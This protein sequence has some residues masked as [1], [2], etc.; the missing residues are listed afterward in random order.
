MHGTITTVLTLVLGLLTST[1][2]NASSAGDQAVFRDTYQQL[3]EINTTFSEGSCTRAAQAMAVRLSD[4]GMPEQDIH[5]IVPPEW[6]TQGKLVAILHGSK[7][8]LEPMLL[9]AH[10]DVV[11]ARREDWERDPFKLVE[12]NGYFYARGT[13]DNKAMA[14]IF[15]DALVRYKQIGYQPERTIKLALTC[16]EE[17]ASLF[18]G[19][20]YLVE[21][22]REL[23]D[24]G[25]ALNEG[26][27]GVLDKMGQRIY[28]GVQAGE[29]LYQDYSFEVTNP[30]GHSSRPVKDN[31]IYRLGHALERVSQYD[32]LVEFNDTTRAYFEQM[33]AIKSGQLGAD[34]QAI[35]QDPPEADALARIIT[36]P[37]Y[38]SILRT[39]CVATTI[40]GGDALNALP[41][42]VVANVNCRIFPGHSQQE[43]LETLERVVDDPGVAISFVNAPGT[44]SPPPPL[45][46]EILGPIEA[47]TGQM[48]PGVPVLPTMAAGYTDGRILTPA[49]IPT[50]GVS[51]LFVQPGTV[52]AHGVNEKL[53]VQSLYEGR[54]F[55]D[56]LIRLYAGGS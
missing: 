52:N 38:N 10:I 47:V 21:N 13:A 19:A 4:A 1:I 54:E 31:A 25:F 24:A 53:P 7:A 23:I 11:E 44:T 35:L 9:L 17:T 56:R 32:F 29:K 30:G 40:E 43:I 48:W 36:T 34:M 16:G 49:G 37:G 18:D 28:N 12:E 45:T 26:G 15:V 6:P 8:K 20:K 5:V 22:H 2:L 55:L 42:R 51:G 46:A 14:A 41:Q 39:T 50:Y 3:V 33:S 27:R